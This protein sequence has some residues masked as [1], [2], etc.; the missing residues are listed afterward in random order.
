MCI[1]FGCDYCDTIKGIGPKR[2]FKLIKEHRSIPEILKK[3]NKK[4]YPVPENWNYAK[5]KEL[6]AAPAVLDPNKIVVRI[7]ENRIELS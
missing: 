5:A 1:L 4:K 6:F 3:I 2:A 7:I